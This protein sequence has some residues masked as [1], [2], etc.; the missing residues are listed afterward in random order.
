LFDGALK[1]SKVNLNYQNKNYSMAKSIKKEK[2]KID[3]WL[4]V[5]FGLLLLLFSV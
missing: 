4:T 3:I 2:G 1:K 5:C